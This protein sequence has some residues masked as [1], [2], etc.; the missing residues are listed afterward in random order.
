V[1]FTLKN[2]TRIVGADL[3]GDRFDDAAV[4][5]EDGKLCEIS[6]TPYPPHP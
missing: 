5:A 4:L 1:P 2:T 6:N 3:H